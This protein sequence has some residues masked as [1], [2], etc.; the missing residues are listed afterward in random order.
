MSV[1]GAPPLTAPV[2]RA[3]AD[4]QASRFK[5]LPF[6]QSL[7]VVKGDEVTAS[8]PGHLGR[9]RVPVRLRVR[10]LEASYDFGSVI[11]YGGFGIVCTYAQTAPLLPDLPPVFCV[12]VT[13]DLH[14]MKA[15]R[16]YVC[17]NE[18]VSAAFPWAVVDEYAGRFI[19]AMP[20]YD[21][22]ML[23]WAQTMI[24]K[25]R[26][27]RPSQIINIGVQLLELL[28]L[29]WSA[30][31]TYCDMKAENCLY[32]ACG[33]EEDV[34]ATIALGDA[35]SISSLANKDGFAATKPPPE[36]FSRGYY[37][38]EADRRMAVMRWA[39]GVTL[40]TFVAPDAAE[41]LDT[42]SVREDLVDIHAGNVAAQRKAIVKYL[43]HVL[44]KH[45]QSALE[46]PLEDLMGTADAPSTLSFEQLISRF[47][48]YEAALEDGEERE[49]PGSRGRAS[50]GYTKAGIAATAPSL[51]AILEAMAVRGAAGS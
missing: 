12:K 32:I 33:D 50:E 39:T 10:A 49:A 14:E 30:G 40:V 41:L 51:A 5:Y 45:N 13:A 36:L 15:V 29:L 16:E 18:R 20:L 3:T 26:P 4:F 27:L 11:G 8:A 43:K 2:C 24:V 48:A 17:A 28:S 25:Q 38:S 42:A 9:V 34:P 44:K 37:Q 1:V 35:G 21:N 6:F 22:D 7:Y 46:Q 31:L 47:K 23:R 19:I